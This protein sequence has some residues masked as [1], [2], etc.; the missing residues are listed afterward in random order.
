MACQLWYSF[1]ETSLYHFKSHIKRRGKKTETLAKKFLLWRD[2][3]YRFFF[4]ARRPQK[5]M[6]HWLVWL[7]D[8]RGPSCIMRLAFFPMVDWLHCHKTSLT[9]A[10]HSATFR[11][12]LIFPRWFETLVKSCLNLGKYII[13]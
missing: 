10:I 3:W 4:Q 1:E 13:F 11:D 2:K 6:S 12:N 5:K 9:L 8:P 7:R